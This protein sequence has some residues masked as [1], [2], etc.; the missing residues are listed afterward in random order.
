VGKGVSWQQP[1]AWLNRLE[2]VSIYVN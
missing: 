2:L 1:P